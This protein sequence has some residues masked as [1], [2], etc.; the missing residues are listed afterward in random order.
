[1]YLEEL[2]SEFDNT[3]ICDGSY[4]IGTE[5]IIDT[6]K[7]GAK[8]LGE[9]IVSLFKRLIIWFKAL[10]GKM[11]GKYYWSGLEI[12]ATN[13]TELFVMLKKIGDD[14]M[15]EARKVSS[16]KKADRFMSV[17]II[18][19]VTI[20]KIELTMDQ[21]NSK[22]F[23]AVDKDVKAGVEP[24]AD[25]VDTSFKQSVD[26]ICSMLE[27]IKKNIENI[28]QSHSDDE[29][30]ITK[31]ISPFATLCTKV[32]GGYADA[33]RKCTYAGRKDVANASI[34]LDDVEMDGK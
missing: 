3:V 23:A 5:G 28:L 15:A 31:F 20:N 30:A 17:D 32:Q 22:V 13:Y 9:K 34:N 1:M 27:T 12:I 14:I 6:I 29:E 26:K 24:K 21:I 4:D 10:L 11:K 18:P 19:K 16:K 25:G 7:D 8:F 2:L 33:L